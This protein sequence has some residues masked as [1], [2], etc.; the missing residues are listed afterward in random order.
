ML[1]EKLYTD[2]ADSQTYSSRSVLMKFQNLTSMLRARYGPNSREVEPDHWMF[3]VMTGENRSQVVHLICKEQN[4]N[5]QDISRII[6]DSPIGPVPPRADFETLLRMNA[7]LDV[8]AICIEDFRDEEN[9]LVTYFTLRA[10][11]LVSTAD[12]EEIW[13]MVEKVSYVADRLERDIYASDLH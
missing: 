13:E 11:H 8:G 7:E 6:A 10:S 1:A 4:V 2:Y 12:F 3:E 5:G 9:Q